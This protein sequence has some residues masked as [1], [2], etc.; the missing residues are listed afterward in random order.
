MTDG[1]VETIR[2]STGSAIVLGLARGLLKAP[3][4]TIYLLTYRSGRCTANCGFCA[5]AR[6]SRTRSD[7]LSRVIWPP[8]PLSK[9]KEKIASAYSEGKIKR[10]CIQTLNYR[11]VLEDLLHIVKELKSESQIP[12]SISCQ[13]LKRETMKYLFKIGVDRIGVALD[14]ATKD[15]FER[16]KGSEVNGPYRWERQLEALSDAVEI[17]GKGRVTTHLIVGL[18]ETEREMV[19]IIQWCVD[20]GI[21]P[22]LFA[23]TP[24]PGTMLEDSTQPPIESYRRIQVARYLILKKMIRF[25]DI[26]FDEKGE[27]KCFPLPK[28]HMYKIVMSGVPFMT[29]GCPGCNRPFYNEKVTGPIYNVPSIDVWEEIKELELERLERIINPCFNVEPVE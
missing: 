24:I 5:Q 17:F 22:A 11:N 4:T 8:F 1:D 6:S 2:V 7:M 26:E 29:S 9:V 21:L 15:L 23:F 25:E 16:V 19:E 14:A 13:P 12:I 3:P 18:G 10:V 20:N 28:K 27:I